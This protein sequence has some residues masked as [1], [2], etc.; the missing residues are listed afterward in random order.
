MEPIPAVRRDKQIP[1]AV[2]DIGNRYSSFRRIASASSQRRGIGG[3][4]VVQSP[5]GVVE[6]LI[7]REVQCIVPVAGGLLLA[8]VGHRPGDL[9]RIADDPGR[10]R[11]R[12]CDLQVRAGQG[13]RYAGDVVR[14]V[15]FPLIVP[16]IRDEQQVAGAGGSGW[17][18]YISVDAVADTRREWRV[19]GHVVLHDERIYTGVE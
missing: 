5:I 19:A 2:C 1:G 13:D 12:R 10:R 9:N 7:R 4:H 15:R 16:C 11:R 6:R 3:Q 8:F 14:L 17:E 18:D